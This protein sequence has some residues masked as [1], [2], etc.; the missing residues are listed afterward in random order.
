MIAQLMNERVTYAQKRKQ[1]N[2]GTI[3]HLAG[4]KSTGFGP[5]PPHSPSLSRYGGAIPVRGRR[6]AHRRKHPPLENV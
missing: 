1:G 4:G 3:F 2:S 5:S 6:G